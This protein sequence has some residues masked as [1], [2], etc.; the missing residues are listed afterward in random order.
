MTATSAKFITPR[1]R[2][3]YEITKEVTSMAM[4]DLSY[5]LNQITLLK[6]TRMAAEMEAHSRVYDP[7]TDPHGA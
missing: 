2:L 6:A 7:D 5:V 1:D 4:D 3:V